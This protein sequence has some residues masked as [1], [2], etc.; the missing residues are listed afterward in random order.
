[1]GNGLNMGSTERYAIG[2]LNSQHGEAYRMLHAALVR[3]CRL[4]E[5][6]TVAGRNQQTLLSKAIRRRSTIAHSF[7]VTQLGLLRPACPE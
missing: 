5:D 7:A 2:D 3:A 1:M 6:E 4:P